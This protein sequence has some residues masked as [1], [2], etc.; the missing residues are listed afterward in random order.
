MSLLDAV[1]TIPL[2]ATE[3]EKKG[4]GSPKAIWL[5]D[6]AVRAPFEHL[7]YRTLPADYSQ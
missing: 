5:V 4:A 3:S 2:N 1:Q 6:F 7:A